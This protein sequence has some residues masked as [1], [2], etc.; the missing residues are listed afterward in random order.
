MARACSCPGLTGTGHAVPS[1]PGHGVSLAPRHQHWPGREHGPED[2]FPQGLKILFLQKPVMARV[3]L[4][5]SAQLLAR[6][7]F[8]H[9]W[10]PLSENIEE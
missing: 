5:T 7:Y 4:A 2:T 6:D 1:L 9:L 10:L 8:L 3:I